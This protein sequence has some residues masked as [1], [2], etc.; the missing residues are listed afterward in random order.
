MPQHSLLQHD[1]FWDRRFLHRG[2][3]ALS[4]LLYGALCMEQAA[5]GLT[6]ACCLF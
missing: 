3:V 2:G 5:L 6:D 1:P 4:G